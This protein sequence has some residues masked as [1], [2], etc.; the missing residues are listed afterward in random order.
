MYKAF[1]NRVQSDEHQTL[2]YFYL[3]DGVSL[4]FECVSLELPWKDNK[5]QVSCIPKGTYKV[6][7]KRSERYKNHFIL[8]NVP[9]RTAIL[10][11]AGNFNSHTKGCILLG[12]SFGKINKDALLDITASRRATSEL[13]G[14]ANG[15]GFELTIS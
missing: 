6:S 9:N 7:Q 15:E 4:M 2:G 1:L 10:I 11:H 14:I 8:E 5:R 3:Y 13:L 12:T